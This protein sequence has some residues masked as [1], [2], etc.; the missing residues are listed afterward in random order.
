MTE[1]DETV[2]ETDK[3]EDYLERVAAARNGVNN[4]A[5]TTGEA[6]LLVDAFLK[7]GLDARALR[8]DQPK[9][10]PKHI[11]DGLGIEPTF[12]F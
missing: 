4:P 10:R 12:P 8:A 5:P 7:L 6:P 1:T 3:S 9:Q 11:P 2:Q